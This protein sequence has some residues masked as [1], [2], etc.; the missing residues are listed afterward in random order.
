MATRGQASATRTLLADKT[1]DVVQ[2]GS[3]ITPIFSVNLTLT[4][5]L[6]I[7]VKYEMATKLELT[8]ETKQDL[9]IGYTATGDSITQFPDG[10]K[11]RNDM[12]ATLSLGLGY[13]I[14]PK[15]KLAL[16]GNIFFDK[17]ADYGHK[18]DLDF[19]SSTPATHIGNSE[20]IEHNGFTINGALEYD[21]SDKILVSGGYIYA[22]KGVNSRYQSDLTFGNAT[23]TFGAGGAYSF[24]DKIKINLGASY[25]VYMKDEKSLVHAVSGT[26]YSI[27]AIES[28]KKSTFIVGLGL[29]IA[30]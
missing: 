12:P 19:D 1:A 9:L 21:I 14:S 29:D 4:E 18:A 24:T 25:T 23:H 6:N 30:F 17:T 16:G 2:K 10:E 27:R 15:L 8:N 13:Q 22:N 3:G 5:K 11:T 26:E 28:Y 20:I 7:A